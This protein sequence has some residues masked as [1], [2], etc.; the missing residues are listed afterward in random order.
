[1]CVSA[2]RVSSELKYMCFCMDATQLH[3]SL[4]C[5]ILC[6]VALAVFGAGS[7]HRCC[8]ASLAHGLCVPLYP[9]GRCRLLLLDNIAAHIWH[10]KGAVFSAANQQLP[11]GYQQQT[12]PRWQQHDNNP[13]QP[14]QQQWPGQQFL[15]QQQQHQ[16]AQGGYGPAAATAAAGGGA[17]AA[18]A[19]EQQQYGGGG[20]GFDA[21][22]VQAAIAALLQAL[23][24][25]WRMPVVITKQT[26]VSQSDK[27]GTPKLVQREILTGALQVRSMLGVLRGLGVLSGTEG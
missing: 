20:P 6:C 11:Y 21:L 19:Q 23:S 8:S 15:P 5:Y 24:Q 2:P 9:Q 16:Q 14:H 17:G 18:H 12:A 7:M 27:S 3:R 26:G 25:R 10:D 4:L 1:M 13:Q 22:R